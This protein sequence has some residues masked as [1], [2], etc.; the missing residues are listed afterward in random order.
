MSQENSG[1]V[2]LQELI[3]KPQ[4]IFKLKLKVKLQDD[5]LEGES[6]TN[7]FNELTKTII[8]PLVNKYSVLDELY[9]DGLDST[10]VFGQTKIVLDGIGRRLLTEDIPQIKEKLQDDDREEGDEEGGNGEES[11]EESEAEFGKIQKPELEEFDD[12]EVSEDSQEYPSDEEEEEEDGEEEEEDGDGDEVETLV[13]KDDHEKGVGIGT[14]SEGD[15]GEDT[16]VSQGDGKEVQKDTF[17]LNDGFFDIDQYNKQVLAMEKE[18]NFDDEDE[19]DEEEIDYFASLSDEGDGDD[20]N[21]EEEQMDYYDDFYDKPGK[22][23]NKLNKGRKSKQEDDD[24]DED[25]DDGEVSEYDF[26]DEE[27][28]KAIDSARLDLFADESSSKPPKNNKTENLS[29]FEKQQRA[30]QQEIAKLEAELV[31]D[32]KWTL[33]GEVTSNERPKESLLEENELAFDRTAKPVPTITEEVTESIEDLIR[34]RIKEDDFNDLPR[35]IV[36]DLSRFHKGPQAEVSEQKSTRTLAELYEDEYNQVDAQQEQLNEEEK[37][38]H[39]E[40]SELFMT[41]THKLDALCS[42][43]FI[44]KPHEKKNIEIKVT[45]ASA[46]SISMED[47]Q[48]LHISNEAQLA[49]QEIYKIGDDAVKGDGVKGKSEVQLKSGLSYS[50]DEI[51]RDEKQRLRR[52]NKRKKAKNFREREEYKRQRTMQEPKSK[53][54]RTGAGEVIDTLSRA[55]NVTVIGKKGEL[56]DAKGNLKKSNAPQT[57]TNFKL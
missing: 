32:K 27:Y 50:K 41:V 49:P 11:E 23:Q 13:G 54:R 46:P 24:D 20:E 28:D 56:R 44:P 26:G 52:A 22:F 4:D 38:Q 18:D 7:L 37:R 47:A 51:D 35:R 9:I 57:S 42:A 12:D 33:K 16:D 10:Q 2:T 19:D 14:D 53:E 43:H 29:S 55:K 6:C 17:G 8:N 1:R 40:I 3:Q 45:D 30:L 36:Q 15:D 34:K 5:S 25:D 48:P 31:A 21:G 39:D